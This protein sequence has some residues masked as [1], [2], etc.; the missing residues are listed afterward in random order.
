MFASPSRLIGL[1]LVIL[2]HVLG[3]SAAEKN[4]YLKEHYPASGKLGLRVDWGL[5][6]RHGMSVR[7]EKTYEWAFSSRLRFSGSLKDVSNE[8]IAGITV[9]AFRDMIENLRL[10]QTDGWNNLDKPPSITP[11]VM[12][13][14]VYDNEMIIG[15][16]QRG[17]HGLSFID[18]PAEVERDENGKVKDP[19]QVSEVYTDLMDCEA[20]YSRITGIKTPNSINHINSRHCG[21][22]LVLHHWKRI[23][24]GKDIANTENP[25]IFSVTKV[26]NPATKTWEIVPLDPCGKLPEGGM[27]ETRDNKHGC[28]LFVTYRNPAVLIIPLAT[29]P[30]QN[31]DVASLTGE[32]PTR[33]ELDSCIKR[34]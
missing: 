5:L 9:Q 6:T 8:T 26:N 29:V 3:V 23:F 27:A 11:G 13:V 25:R 20:E 17:P 16:S 19:D 4:V 28:M 24:K 12:T 18:I 2:A 33:L 7:K 22:V 1:G 34:P 31:V 14:L 30:E 10:Y 15:S 21:E 32:L